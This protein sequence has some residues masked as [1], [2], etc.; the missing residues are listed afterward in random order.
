MAASGL[1]GN[2]LFGGGLAFAAAVQPGPLQ[3]FLLSRVLAAGWRRTLPACLSPVLSDGPIALL[4]ILLLSRCPPGALHVLRAAGGL[5]L[6]YLAGG[7]LRQWRRPP[8]PSSLPSAPRTLLQATLVNLL[9]PNPYL[10]WGLVLGPAVA[11]A[12]SRSP[13]HAL[14]LVVAFY[15]TMVSTM[16]GFVILAGTARFLD[17]SRQ[18]ALAGVSAVLLGCLGIALLIVGAGDAIRWLRGG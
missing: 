18:R 3:A 4:A 1:L 16:A 13:S 6:V 2:V 9:N 12:W 15:V 7:A 11:A 8:A 14:G 17:R 10:A 5:L